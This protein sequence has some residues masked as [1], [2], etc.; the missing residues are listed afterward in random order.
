[1]AN[2]ETILPQQQLSDELYRRLCFFADTY[3]LRHQRLYRYGWGHVLFACYAA[4]PAHLSPDLLHKLRL[5]FRKYSSLGPPAA[6]AE[7]SPLAVND[8]LLSNLLRETGYE[9]FEM[10]EELRQYL[11]WL[12]QHSTVL[13][14]SCGISPLP[15]YEAD[16]G[17]APALARLHALAE[18]LRRYASEFYTAPDPVTLSLREAQ[19]WTADAWQHPERAA[20]RL[21]D[22]LATASQPAERYHFSR[23]GQRLAA[24]YELRLNPRAESA[25]PAFGA[26]SAYTQG[27]SALYTGQVEQARGLFAGLPNLVSGSGAASG[28]AIRLPLPREVEAELLRQRPDLA[29]APEAAAD[30]QRRPRHWNSLDERLR[31]PYPKAVLAI[32]D[33]DRTALAEAL[34]LLEQ[35]LQTEHADSS[36]L[37]ADY[38]DI[39]AGSGMGTFVAAMVASRHAA[40][41]ISQVLQEQNGAFLQEPLPLDS[42]RK[43]AAFSDVIG[44]FFDGLPFPNEA[45]R[46]GL[47]LA[48]EDTQRQALDLSGNLHTYTAVTKTDLDILL[49]HALRASADEPETG[50][51]STQR[52]PNPF[53]SA[54]YAPQYSLELALTEE[55]IN[56]QPSLGW[57]VSPAQFLLVSLKPAP[58]AATSTG[59]EETLARNLRA[60]IGW[61]EAQAMARIGRQRLRYVDWMAQLA[62]REEGKAVEW[63][64]EWKVEGAKPERKIDAL[65]KEIKILISEDEIPKAFSLLRKNLVNG[66]YWH[67]TF[68]LQQGQLS[69]LNADFAK[70]VLSHDDD[71]A[72]RSQLLQSS[73]TLIDAIQES[74][75]TDGSVAQVDPFTLRTTFIELKEKIAEDELAEVIEVLEKMQIDSTHQYLLD[76]VKS[77]ILELNAQQVR[78]LISMQESRVSRNKFREALLTLVT[79]ISQAQQRASADEPSGTAPSSSRPKRRGGKK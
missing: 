61:L 7:I 26:L 67:N 48:M 78:G 47:L 22:Q 27:L 51:E 9:R 64:V 31:A 68:I 50:L 6:G 32:G 76:R 4:F 69:N 29:H 74:D 24:Q 3:C 23:L 15:P 17:L 41:E 12:L 25:P 18:F 1:M 57:S 16:Q 54:L 73:L 62:R 75:L 79:Q 39:I 30:Q 38:F 71:L 49:Y 60:D 28:Q 40:S 70:G 43:G 19:L 44:R 59:P 45:L 2:I 13:A 35:D 36:L 5:N 55:L 63:P 37:L 53:R 33:G 14:D 21:R 8:L 34:L 10:P 58:P 66:S 77:Q 52:P 20:A 42:A 56:H 11:L 65:K 72:A 46:N